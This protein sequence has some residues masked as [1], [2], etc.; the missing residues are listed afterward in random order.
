V[1]LNLNEQLNRFEYKKKFILRFRSCDQS[2][3]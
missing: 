3:V 2:N 1:V